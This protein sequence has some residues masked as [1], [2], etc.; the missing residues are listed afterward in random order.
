MVALMCVWLCLVQ[1]TTRVGRRSAVISVYQNND[2]HTSPAPVQ[3]TTIVWHILW[4]VVGCS[5]LRVV[6]QVVLMH[7]AQLITVLLACCQSSAYNWLLF[8]NSIAR[9]CKNT[10]KF[11][12]VNGHLPYRKQHTIQV[13]MFCWVI[14]PVLQVRLQSFYWFWSAVIKPYVVY[15]NTR[16]SC[17]LLLF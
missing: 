6:F 7:T 10:Q 16:T 1:P 3:T 2:I 4:I 17:T 5:A 14:S 12:Q 13:W 15:A 8:F 9:Q 11:V